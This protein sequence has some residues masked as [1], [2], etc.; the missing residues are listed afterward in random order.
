V[1]VFRIAAAS[2]LL[3]LLTACDSQA[4]EFSS[5]T[6]GVS[7]GT[8]ITYD[9]GPTGESSEA[10]T[11]NTQS[12]GT[13]SFGRRIGLLQWDTSGGVRAGYTQNYT[14][15]FLGAQTDLAVELGA[16]PYEITGCWSPYLGVGGR[17]AA[18]PSWIL[19]QTPFLNVL[20]N[21]NRAG[22]S[23]L[24]GSAR[25]ALG[26]ACVTDKRAIVLYGFT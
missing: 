15:P 4:D 16:R 17:A 11:V 2:A 12:A 24:V 13:R 14:G 25:I 18:S 8:A 10:L 22:G 1:T 5:K 3:Y 26:L 23:S 21:L 19:S 6:S 7:I 9:G 20:N